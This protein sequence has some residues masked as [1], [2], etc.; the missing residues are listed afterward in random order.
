MRIVADKILIA[1]A[2]RAY[3]G[4]KPCCQLPCEALRHFFRGRAQQNPVRS[5][6]I[7]RRKTRIVSPL[8]VCQ[9]GDRCDLRQLSSC[10]RAASAEL[11]CGLINADMFRR[12]RRATANLRKTIRDDHLISRLHLPGSHFDGRIF[13]LFSSSPLPPTRMERGRVGE[14]LHDLFCGEKS[15]WDP[16]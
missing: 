2:A 15:C 5:I 13:R 6:R 1:V 3:R 12:P 8:K 11:R 9:T 16:S 4:S 10:L 7:R 14:L